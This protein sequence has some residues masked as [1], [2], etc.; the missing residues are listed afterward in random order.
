MDRYNFELEDVSN[1]KLLQ[2]NC[3]HCQPAMVETYALVYHKKM[4][5]ERDSDEK[6]DVMA[7][8][9]QGHKQCDGSSWAFPISE[10]NALVQQHSIA[11]TLTTNN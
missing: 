11:T 7:V 2:I 8:F 6:K 4:T 5:V 1:I 10:D 9:C 3:S